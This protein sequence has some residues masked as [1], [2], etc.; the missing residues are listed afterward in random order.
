MKQIEEDY[1]KDNLPVANKRK[2]NI[3]NQFLNK[4][5]KKKYCKLEKFNLKI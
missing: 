4:N 5:N 1:K 3:N 2:V